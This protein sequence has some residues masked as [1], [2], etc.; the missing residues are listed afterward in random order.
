ML[1]KNEGK[2]MLTTAAATTL[3]STS[4]TTTTTTT[5]VNDDARWGRSEL[6]ARFECGCGPRPSLNWGLRQVGNWY[7]EK[8]NG[9]SKGCVWRCIWRLNV[10]AIVVVCI[11]LMSVPIFSLFA[12]FVVCVGLIRNEKSKMRGN[13]MNCFI[14]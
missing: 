11:C 5:F 14:K 6:V 2:D 8:G 9:R 13:K 7:K 4:T 3:T 12:W 1:A 10:V